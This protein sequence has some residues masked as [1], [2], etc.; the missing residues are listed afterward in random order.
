MSEQTGTTQLS[1][2]YSASHSIWTQKEGTVLILALRLALHRSPSPPSPCDNLTVHGSRGG[3]AEQEK[4]KTDREDKTDRC[5][6]R[7]I[8]SVHNTFTDR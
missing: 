1:S 2:R 5:D 8:R 3:V 6:A 4:W 7:I